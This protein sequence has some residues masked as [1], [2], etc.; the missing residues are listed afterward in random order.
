MCKIKKNE[1][2]ETKADIINLVTAIIF[3]QSKEF[4]E[5]EVLELVKYYLEGSS[6]QIIEG[7]LEKIIQKDIDVMVKN[8]AIRCIHGKYVPNMII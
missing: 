4:V 6:C 5:T 1:D 8:Q 3:R 7:E 2:I